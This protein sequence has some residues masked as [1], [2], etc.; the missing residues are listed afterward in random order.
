[1]H[2]R[3]GDHDDSDR[4]PA[5]RTHR[6]EHPLLPRPQLFERC[7][8]GSV[9]PFVSTVIAGWVETQIHPGVERDLTERPMTRRR[10]PPTV[11]A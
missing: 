8:V 10:P 1:V 4:S 5:E 6:A 11:T 7:H 3:A 9:G 2:L